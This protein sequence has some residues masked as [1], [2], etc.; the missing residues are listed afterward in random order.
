[1]SFQKAGQQL[2]NLH[3]NTCQSGLWFMC[4]EGEG[5][6][7]C[8]LPLQSQSST[9]AL[10]VFPLVGFSPS[11]SNS[12]MRTPCVGWYSPPEL[13]V[14]SARKLEIQVLPD[15]RK[16]GNV[17][18]RSPDLLILP[19]PPHKLTLTSQGPITKILALNLMSMV[20]MC[21]PVAVETV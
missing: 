4:V 9:S 13:S 19:L 18:S 17:S 8:L 21:L 7:N 11:D 3:R 12:R 15:C 14:A 20:R 6:L 1:M 16:G 5:G 10:K 2:S